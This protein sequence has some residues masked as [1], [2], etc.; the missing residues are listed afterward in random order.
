MDGSGP[1]PVIR[2][3]EGTWAQPVREL[4]VTG[5]GAGGDSNAVEGKQLVG[6]MQG[7]GKLWQKTYRVHLNA[8]PVR[9]EE[10]VQVWKTDFGSFWPDNNLFHA[11]L[12]G[13]TP[14]EVALISGKM[15]GGLTLSTGVY[16]IYS[17]DLSFSYM[18]PEGHPWAGMITFSADELEGAVSAQVELLIRSFDPLTELGMAFGGHRMEDKIWFHTLGSV[19][20]RFGA[21]DAEVEKRIV[22]VDKKRQWDRFGNWKKSVAVYSMT[23]PFRRRPA[24]TT[25]GA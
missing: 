24:V 3:V 10:V 9:P 1:D 22:C 12:A 17:D 18:N 5:D 14:G 16:V 6:P 21:H 4:H 19:A 2:R 25:T 11:P 13:I 8:V 23:K 15:P 7:F 20:A